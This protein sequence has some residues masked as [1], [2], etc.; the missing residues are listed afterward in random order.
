MCATPWREMKAI[1]APEGRE[2]MVMGDEGGP[3]GCLVCQ[4]REGGT[5][6]EHTVIIST[7]F[8]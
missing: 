7:V 5:R 1:S 2:E 4:L 3:H 8:L 6:D